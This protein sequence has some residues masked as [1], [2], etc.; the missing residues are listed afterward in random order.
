MKVIWILNSPIG[1]ISNVLNLSHS[2]SG[3]W[4]DAA[5]ESLLEQKNKVELTVLTTA[6]IPNVMEKVQN[7]VTY[8]CIPAGKMLQG[9]RIPKTRMLLWEQTISKIQPDVIHIW[10]T[11]F[12]LGYDL[13]KLFP[14][15]PFLYTMQGVMSYISKSSELI[16]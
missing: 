6:S 16:G 8:L 1:E 2:Q 3:T 7:G 12:S 4:I 5:M 15:I 13:R 9:T 14:K 10:G 11:E